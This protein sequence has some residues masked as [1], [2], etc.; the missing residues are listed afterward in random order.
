MKHTILNATA[1]EIIAAADGVEKAY[2]RFFELVAEEY[3]D[4]RAKELSAK[5]A[6]YRTKAAEF[7]GASVLQAMAFADGVAVEG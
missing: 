5:F 4:E 1:N 3:G 7:V 6:D 2:G